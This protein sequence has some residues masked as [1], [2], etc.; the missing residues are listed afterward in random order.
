MHRPRRVRSEGEAIT[1]APHSCIMLLRYGF[2]AYETLTMYTV[3]F[4]P[5]MVQ[6][7]AIEEPHWPA[8]VSVAIRTVP[9]AVL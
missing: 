1:S 5:N 2:C 8:P 4:S 7:I 3:H 9:A 6:A